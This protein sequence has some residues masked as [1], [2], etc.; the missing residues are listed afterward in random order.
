MRQNVNQFREIS[1]SLTPSTKH[2]T[3][4][5]EQYPIP[6]F[7]EQQCGE[8]SVVLGDWSGIDG[9]KAYSGGAY[10]RK[11][12][13]INGSDL[14]NKLVIDLGDLVS[15]AELIINGKSAGIRLSSPWKFDITPYAKTGENKVEILIYNT[16]ANNYT[17]VPTMYLGS[18][19][20]GLIG[21]VTLKVIQ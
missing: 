3:P 12:I 18:I 15:S 5:V 17:T 2:Q 8:G 11:T 9:L 10:Y 1:K 4:K 14:K 16:I 20:A 21:P 19:K 13:Q 7:I 6:Q